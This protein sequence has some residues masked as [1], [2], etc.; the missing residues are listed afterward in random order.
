DLRMRP[1]GGYGGVEQAPAG[2]G[3]ERAV[4]IDVAVALAVQT[5]TGEPEL[6]SEARSNVFR[7]Q[8]RIDPLRSCDASEPFALGNVLAAMIG[9]ERDRI[10][11]M[12]PVELAEKVAELA[13]E[14]QQVK[15][16]LL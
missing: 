8:R 5:G 7:P 6:P 2:G 13:V 12:P 11:D 14:L 15:A 9:S 1:V 4:D 10:I 3:R 16:H